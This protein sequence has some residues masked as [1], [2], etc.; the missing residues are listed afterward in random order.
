MASDKP[1]SF[2]LVFL[3]TAVVTIAAA[4]SLLISSMLPSSA[5]TQASFAGVTATLVMG[6][7][8]C[9][10]DA[11]SADALV[12][13]REVGAL[14]NLLPTGCPAISAP[15]AEVAPAGRLDVDCDGLVRSLD[16]LLILWYAI[17]L[18]VQQPD[19]CP[20][21]GSPLGE[22]PTPTTGESSTPTTTPCD[23]CTATPT[24]TPTATVTPTPTPTV[25]AT[26]TQADTAD[27]KAVSL[28]PF[29]LPPTPIP[30][31]TETT[32]TVRFDATLHDNGPLTAD[33]AIVSLKAAKSS[34]QPTVAFS[35]TPEQGDDCFNEQSPAP[36]DDQ[37]GG[38]RDELIFNLDLPVSGDVGTSRDLKYMCIGGIGNFD[39]QVTV[40]VLPPNGVTDP[41]PTNNE[42]TFVFSNICQ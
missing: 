39:I 3:L 20:A 5:S 25:T 34:G 32:V 9:D 26:P 15:H 23:L 28:V 10:G 13:L 17:E 22:E 24:P 37:L 40:W 35:W 11:D 14:P 36:C 29:E 33:G 21:I 16:G 6:D 30:V 1:S 42:Q 8:D 38:F 2:R 41:E 7:G 18:P 12:A 31:P 19:G 27:V 4:A